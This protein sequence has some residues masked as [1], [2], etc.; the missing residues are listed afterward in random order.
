VRFAS[1]HHAQERRDDAADGGDL[2]PVA[3]ARRREGVVVAE[4][5]VRAVDEMDVQRLAP[6]SVYWYDPFGQKWT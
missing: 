2:A 3:V 5:L 6:R 4:K 1:G